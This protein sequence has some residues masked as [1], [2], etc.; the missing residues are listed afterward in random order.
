[1]CKNKLSGTLNH[2]P[3]HQELTSYY[4]CFYK[5]YCGTVLTNCNRHC[6]Q[7][8]Y[9][10]HETLNRT[11]KHYKYEYKNARMEQYL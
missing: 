7:L 10:A 8:N 3:Y 9:N 5:T 6:T 4:I 1:M 11:L 2:L